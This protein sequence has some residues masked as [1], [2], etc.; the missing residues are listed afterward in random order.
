MKETEK[1]AMIVCGTL[2]AAALVAGAVW[3]VRSS[4]QYKALRAV[5]RT[6]TVIRRVGHVLSRIAEATEECL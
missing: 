6:N 3:A 5:R 4:K 2:G 1:T